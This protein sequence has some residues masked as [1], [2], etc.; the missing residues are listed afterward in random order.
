MNLSKVK[1]IISSKIKLKGSIYYSGSS[2]TFYGIISKA[3]QEFPRSDF[4]I[5]TSF[6][7]SIDDGKLISKGSNYFVPLQID[8]PNIME[9][10]VYKKVFMNQANASGDLYHYDEINASEMDEWDVAPASMDWVK[11]KTGVYVN[12]Q[13]LSLSA[14]YNQQVGRIGMGDFLIFMPWSVNASYTPISECRFIDRNGRRWKIED[15][16]D[17]TYFNQCY[18]MRVSQDDR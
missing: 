7:A 14:E 13:N 8:I 1:H 2:K 16:D 17:K 11:K 10:T 15:V 5:L 9:N 18:M 3:T 4:L 6:N 12:F